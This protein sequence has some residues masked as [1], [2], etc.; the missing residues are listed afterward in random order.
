[1]IPVVYNSRTK[2]SGGLWTPKLTGVIEEGD[3]STTRFFIEGTIEIKELSGHLKMFFRG[4]KMTERKF[5]ITDEDKRAL[6]LEQAAILLEAT[7]ADMK[8]REIDFDEEDETEL[9]TKK[10]MEE[11]ENLAAAIIRE[12]KTVVY[13]KLN[14][15][16]SKKRPKKRMTDVHKTG[17]KVYIHSNTDGLFTGADEAFEAGLKDIPDVLGYS[18]IVILKL[19]SDEPKTEEPVIY[20]LVKLQSAK[21]QK[22]RTLGA[23]H[24]TEVMDELARILDRSTIPTEPPE[25]DGPTNG[26]KKKKKALAPPPVKKTRKASDILKGTSY[27]RTLTNNGWAALNKTQDEQIDFPTFLKMIDSLN[28]FMVDA[29]AKR[30]FDA[31]DVG[32][33]G[34]IDMLAFENFLMSYDVLGTETDLTIIDI[35]DSFKVEP[36]EDFKEFFGNKQGLDFSGFCEA[37]Q[38]LGVTKSAVQKAKALQEEQLAMTKMNTSSEPG[39]T[40]VVD[41]EEEEDEQKEK[42][43]ADEET[44]MLEA[45]CFATGCKKLNAHEK[46]MS[47]EE[48]KKGWLKLANVE[49]ELIKRNLKYDKVALSE[50]RNRERLNRWVTDQEKQY[51]IA[52]GKVVETC[53]TV[54]RDRRMRKEEKKKEQAAFREKLLHEAQKFI[55][56]RNQEKRIQQKL[57]EEEKNR[58]RL[59]EKALRIKLLEKQNEAK[60]TQES[61]IQALMQQSESLRI[62]EIKNKGWDR[63]DHSM[64]RLRYIPPVQYETSDARNLLSF[65]VIIDY[66]RNVLDHLPDSNFLFFM[67]AV[68]KLSFA[69]NRLKTIPN[70]LCDCRSLQALEL[71]TNKL[72]YLPG[73]IGNLTCK[74][75]ILNLYVLHVC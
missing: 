21:S 20:G 2:I 44:R 63:I 40:P 55:A 64:K 65:A 60:A 25:A 38:L 66:S 53:E 19:P 9:M 73:D 22:I 18:G 5:V 10:R 37:V 59:E 61:A 4:I 69:Q 70:E 39:S 52:L 54:K 75:F 16:L 43:E 45:F 13:P 7:K 48:L 1:M 51:F 24:L 67:Q 56:I 50:G 32:K 36:T 14:I 58:K 17:A 46:F 33:A 29:Q 72:L 68:K 26:K 8:E 42:E 35:F 57:A 47:L 12:K 74:S 62:Q 27:Y 28:I 71:E 11:A 23:L 41:G 49:E 30:L 31:V 15:F 3:S 34:V 6:V